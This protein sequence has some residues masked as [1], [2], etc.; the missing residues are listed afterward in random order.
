MA[1]TSGYTQAPSTD[2]FGTDT[3]RFGIEFVEIADPG[4]PNDPVVQFMPLRPEGAGAVNYRFRIG[5]YELAK[6]LVASV[7]ATGEL[8]IEHNNAESVA[9]PWSETK[10]ATNMSFYEIAR[11][12]NWL[13]LTTGYPPAYRFSQSAEWQL[14]PLDD[15][16]SIDRLNR[17]RHKGALYFLPSVDEWHKAAFWDPSQQRYWRYP[18]GSDSAPAAVPSGTAPRT[19]VYDQPLEQGPADVE[20]AGGL[21]PFG[22]MAMGGNLWDF[23][24]TAQHVDN[25]SVTDWLLIRGGRWYQ[26]RNTMIAS[27]T[28]QGRPW[29]GN[30]DS[31]A[32]RVGSMPFPET[33]TDEDGVKDHAERIAGTDPEDAND[34]PGLLVVIREKEIDVRF[35]TRGTPRY[36]HIDAYRYYALE[37]APWFSA[38]A[39]TPVP[40]YERVLGEGQDVLYRE[41]TASEEARYFRLRIWLEARLLSSQPMRGEL[42]EDLFGEDPDQFGIEFVTVRDEGNE[43]DLI[44]MPYPLGG[45]GYAY[46]IGKYEISE[47]M[48]QKANRV[49]GLGL[50]VS[51]R[52]VN[53]PATMMTFL[54]LARFVNWLNTS[55]GYAPAYNFDAGGVWR[56]WSPEEAWTEG[57][58]NLYR[59]KDAMYFLPSAGEWYKAA[60]FDGQRYRI[61]P[62]GSDQWPMPV[63][64]GRWGGS[65]V[66]LQPPWA[67]PADVLNAGG[68]SH[69]GT[70]GQ[71]G[72]VMEWTETAVD[73]FNGATDKTLQIRGGDWTA[74]R[75]N[76]MGSSN[77]SS[78]PTG[79]GTSDNIGFRVAARLVPPR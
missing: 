40:G 29:Q 10:P 54:R 70:M 33:D 28:D 67:G 17:Y 16:W 49:G 38:E 75:A 9:A 44:S 53:K 41:P 45:V 30:N 63:P 34:R 61:Y 8:M 73:G 19:A 42:S 68:L 26:G 36:G 32:F 7:N 77:A 2:Y 51:N 65:V 74:V 23:L 47:E 50:T 15:S 62:T 59:H 52:G 37:A 69:C 58:L 31:T 71:A 43:H 4:N 76:L 60:Y 18:T 46:R 5:K 6:G 57:E 78:R 12:I 24:E 3:N 55:K 56:L 48:V 79:G 25:D 11:F 21:S 35:Q 22:V 72:N 20:N 13:N 66:Y 27:G 1:A 39:W 14:W 64:S